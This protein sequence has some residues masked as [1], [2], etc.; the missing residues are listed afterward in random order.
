MALKERDG[1]WHIDARYYDTAGKKQRLQR[2]T[3]LVC[4]PETRVDA[5]IIMQRE[6]TKVAGKSPVEKAAGKLTV[7]DAFEANRL[8]KIRE[9]RAADTM[10]LLEESRVRLYTFFPGD[11]RLDSI[12]AARLKTYV[13]AKL[14]PVH[15]PKIPGRYASSTVRRDLVEL[16]YGI[17]ELGLN[18]PKR[19]KLPK[20][21]AK[22][23]A[24]QP[25]EMRKLLAVIPADRLDYIIV[26]RALGVRKAELYRILGIHVYEERNAVYVDGT[27]SATS[28]RVMPMSVQVR[29]ILLRRKAKYGNGPLFERW[30]PSASAAALKRWCKKAGI[31]HCSYND[32]RRGF[33]TELALENESNKRVA[34][35]MG[36]ADTRMVDATYARL[37][38]RTEFL[39]TAVAKLATYEIGGSK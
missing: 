11:T 30:T 1:H 28:K 6:L 13:N 8:A 5:E 18:V 15:G 3:G 19:P 2:S 38:G 17:Q 33:A 10:R 34:A 16:N 39:D 36:H 29:E 26:Y 35:L 22:E 37:H 32:L 20:T 12:D 23:R 7:A 4:S 24:P 25:D 21:A 31:A 9:G 14:Q 27:K